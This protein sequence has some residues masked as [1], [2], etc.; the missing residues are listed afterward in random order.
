MLGLTALERDVEGCSKKAF[1][2]SHLFIL[3]QWPN[4]LI[5]Y[6][7]HQRRFGKDQEINDGLNKIIHTLNATDMIR[8]FKGKVVTTLH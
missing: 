7:H 1:S 8:A 4:M 6:L 3:A 5:M 2:E